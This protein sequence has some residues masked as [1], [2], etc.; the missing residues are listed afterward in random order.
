MASPTLHVAAAL[1]VDDAGR[2]LLVR[3]RGTTAFM[4]AGGK[5][6]PGEEPHDAV[7]REVAEELGV[8]VTPEQVRPLGHH[9]APAANEPG[10]RI[11]AHVFAVDG[12][13]GAVP[14]AEIAE[15]VWVD[16]EQAAR[17]PLAPLTAT[18]LGLDVAQRGPAGAPLGA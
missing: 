8:T 6:E 16:L 3:K 15:A 14:T 17:L 12:V 2:Y 13:V 5:I 4:Q 7:V 18:L 11:S 9:D 1:I 10:H